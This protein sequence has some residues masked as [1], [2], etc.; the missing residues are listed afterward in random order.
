MVMIHLEGTMFYILLIK[1]TCYN[2]VYVCKFQ[3]TPVCACMPHSIVLVFWN[4]AHKHRGMKCW[5]IK[6]YPTW[7]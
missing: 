3:Y 6:I 5:H 2:I 1:Q 4:I 7:C